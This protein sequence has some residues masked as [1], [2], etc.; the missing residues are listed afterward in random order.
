MA[1]TLLVMLTTTH[2][3]DL[4]LVVAA[5]GNHG[6]LDGGASKEGGADLYRLAFAYHQDLVKGNFCANV[7]R[8]LFYFKFLAG[9][10][11]ILF[12]TGFYDRVHGLDSE[13]NTKG[14]TK[15][16]ALYGNSLTSQSLVEGVW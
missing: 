6:A 10:N 13:N 8:Y 1:L 15:N 4:D 3:E 12:A 11:T 5:V 14:A 7:C 16:R 2:L 9:G